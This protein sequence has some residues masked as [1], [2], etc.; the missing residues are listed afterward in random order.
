[1]GRPKQSERQ[2]TRALAL[3][4]A[5]VLLHS[6]GFLGVSMDDIAKAIGVRKA[7]LYHHF[8]N[9][10]EQIVFEIAMQIMD[11]FA[12][13]LL[14]ALYG[15][16]QIRERLV[17]IV[18]WRL[19][20]PLGTER[21]VREAATYMSTSSQQQIFTALMGQLIAPIH[22][23]FEEGI[24]TGELRS[25]NTRLVSTAFMSVISELGE[26]GQSPT[27]EAEVEEVVNLFLNGI[28]SQ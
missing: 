27:T 22:Q 17:A 1:M 26:L 14:A 19:A 12:D 4:S 3:Q 16:T 7:T 24:H 20:G 2:D 28:G 13:R 9:G 15:K 6:R 8:P 18:H 10:K 21:R 23:V 11:E 5:N 25:H